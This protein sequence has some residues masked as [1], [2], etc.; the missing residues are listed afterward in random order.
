MKIEEV[1]TMSEKQIFERK[2]VRIKPTDLSATLCAFANADG[3]IIAIGISDK[4]KTIEGVDSYQGL[5]N[6]LLRAPMDY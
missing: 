1:L 4:T 6:E 3:G 2:S 5:L